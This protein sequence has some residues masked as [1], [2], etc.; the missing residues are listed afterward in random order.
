MY[1]QSE[2]QAE[3]NL[4]NNF[5]LEDENSSSDSDDELVLAALVSS[6]SNRRRHIIKIKNYVDQVVAAYDEQSFQENFRLTRNAY[7]LV[8]QEVNQNWKDEPLG[9][10]Q[11]SINRQLLAVL[12]LLATPDSYR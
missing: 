5:I 3:Q 8:L 11:I 1:L 10:K 9:R 7:E 4:R 12:W 2:K 6:K